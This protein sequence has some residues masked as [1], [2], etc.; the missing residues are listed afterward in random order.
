M[1][2][3]SRMTITQAKAALKKALTTGRVIVSSHATGGKGGLRRYA[4]VEILA[5][6]ETA[7]MRGEIK[8]NRTMEGRFVGFGV[9]LVISF[10]VIAPSVVV[11]TVFEQGG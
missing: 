1:D 10:E 3:V 2:L 11:V 5:E 7:S 4:D 6:L 8:H 9:E